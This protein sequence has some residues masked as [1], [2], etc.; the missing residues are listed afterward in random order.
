MMRWIVGVEPQVPWPQSEIGYL[1]SAT[2]FGITQLE[3]ED[4]FCPSSPAPLVEVQTEAHGLSAEEVQLIRVRSS[5]IS[6]NGVAFLDDIRVGFAS[7][8]P[9]SLC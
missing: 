4:G 6:L 1:R 2:I 3:H 5:R 9:R 7:R 8:P